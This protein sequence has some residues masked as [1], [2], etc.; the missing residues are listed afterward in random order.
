[1][2]NQPTLLFLLLALFA[3]TLASPLASPFSQLKRDPCV[4]IKAGNWCSTRA[5]KL[6][7]IMGDDCAANTLYSCA[8]DLDPNPL[9][10]ECDSYGGFGG[11]TLTCYEET[12]GDDCEPYPG[13]YAVGDH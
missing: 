6:Q 4:C 13:A 2:L 7:G 3:L 11:E 8:Y 12:Y 9:T 1:M 10:W 5:V